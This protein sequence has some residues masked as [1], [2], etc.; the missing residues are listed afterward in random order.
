[1]VP[2]GPLMDVGLR[3]MRYLLPPNPNSRSMIF[4]LAVP[5]MDSNT[6]RGARSYRATMF[7]LW[8]SMIS[9]IA[10]CAACGLLTS[11]WK[12]TLASFSRDRGRLHPGGYRGK[13]RWRSRVVDRCASDAPGW[14]SGAHGC[15]GG[16]STRRKSM[17]AASDRTAEPPRRPV[18]ACLTAPGRESDVGSTA[19]RTIVDAGAVVIRCAPSRRNI[20]FAGQWTW[21]FRRTSVDVGIRGVLV[22]SAR[23][24][25]RAHG[26]TRSGGFPVRTSGRHDS[27]GSIEPHPHGR[28]T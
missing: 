28:T 10:N 3:E 23:C 19:S 15:P 9:H 24:I 16:A 7:V 13:T 25:A 20:V 4:G 2:F 8:G 22:P 27:D 17:S 6:N 18:E 1:M 14:L 11:A 26:P 5:S 21:S 12:L